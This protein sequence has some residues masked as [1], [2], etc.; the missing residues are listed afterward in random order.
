MLHMP[1]SIAGRDNKIIAAEYV[2]VV[3]NSSARAIAK[4]FTYRVPLELRGVLQIGHEVKVSFGRQILTGFVI[5]PNGAGY[6]QAKDI[7]EITE[8]L[9][10]VSE[11]LLEL[12]HWLSNRYAASLWESL[13][14]VLPSGSVKGK[15]VKPKL[16]YLVESI[17]P[18]EE[19]NA[20]IEKLLLKAPAQGAFFSSLTARGGVAWLQ[21]L[22]VLSK[23]VIS[24]FVEEGVITCKKTVVRRDP[25]VSLGISTPKIFQL[26]PM[27]ENACQ[28]IAEAI[29]DVHSKPP[30]ASYYRELV[31]FGVTGSG[32]TEVYLEGIAETIRHGREAIVL[33][34][35]ISLSC[36][37]AERVKDRFG[38][39]VAILHS[40]LA[41]G[42]RADEWRR[43]AHGEVKIAVGARS[44]LFAP[45]KS[46]GLI[47]MDEEH[48]GAYKQDIT[49]RY[50]TR[51]AARK[52]AELNG[53][54]LVLGSATPSLETLTCAKREDNII[55]RLDKRVDSAVLP[56]VKIVDLKE[57]PPMEG[58]FSP[59][60]LHAIE[61]R[62]KLNQQ[63]IL[64]L[65]RR[66]FATT[67][68]CKECGYAERCPS[69]SV[70]LIFHALHHEL[71]CHYCDRRESVPEVC[72]KCR[73]FNL[74]YKGTGTER[75]EDVLHSIFPAAKILR[76]DRDTTG[77]KGSHGEILAQFA[78][79]EASIL[80]GTQMV[81]KGLDFPYV[82][83]V[84]VLNADAALNF[85]DFRAAE[86]T[87]QLLIQVAGRAGR[88]S[89][90][91]EVI[92]QTYSPAHPAILAAVTQHYES[93]MGTELLS[94][95][96][97]NYPPFAN[98]VRAIVYG[99]DLKAVEDKIHQLTSQ[100]SANDP[101]ITI[102][103]PASCPIEKLKGRYRWHF[104][105]KVSSGI[106]AGEMGRQI[107]SIWR[108]SS[109]SQ[110]GVTLSIDVDPFHLL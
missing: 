51:E 8:E 3:I 89:I 9:P 71:R 66:G 54:V 69:C 11:E 106:L 13:R 40:A 56:A 86:R 110:K 23:K 47:V 84:G 15:R 102:V 104:L 32:K 38:D 78:R 72:P 97:L 48:E 93:F 61:Q 65:N 103:G 28:K 31:L 58:L 74:E 76:L 91:G 4:P 44:A 52:R 41:E 34:P 83:L 105:V 70:A 77:K 80:V 14:M 2:D 81:A 88:S 45:F 63:V 90:P 85:P 7:L 5:A 92:L 26:T 108:N 16:S 79:R 55:L 87:V 96:E 49:P 30:G 20:K 12:A 59:S 17:I 73:S 67:V 98:L 53:S 37:V 10:V 64:F 100:L 107:D 94:R 99:E 62:I 21:E 101:K 46:L 6:A 60:L 42:E 35:E 43:I 19:I 1:C 22:P 24:R 33:V 25:Y 39:Q 27:Q 68:L 36:L 109:G 18:L 57:E 75:V 82:S 50:D 29:R 95:Q